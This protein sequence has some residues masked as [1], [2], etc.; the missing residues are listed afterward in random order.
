MVRGDSVERGD[1]TKGL[2]QQFWGWSVSID[3]LSAVSIKR[4][5]FLYKETEFHAN[6]FEC[7]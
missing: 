5:S 4:K 7:H 2:C 1:S 3:A 6:V